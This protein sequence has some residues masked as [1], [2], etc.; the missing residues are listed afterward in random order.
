MSLDTFV[1]PTIV[2]LAPT[3]VV[4]CVS[5]ANLYA[6]QDPDQFGAS[7]SDMAKI[8]AWLQLQGFSVVS[9]ARSRTWIAAS[10]TAR[11][12]RNGLHAD[13]H[14]FNVNGEV[15]YAN[16]TNPA[17]PAAFAGMVSS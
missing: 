15:H 12:V 13:I 1:K 9:T 10:G 8:T 14:R 6:Q 2:R 17:L 16:A 7:S 11:Q 3:A 5:L 4:L